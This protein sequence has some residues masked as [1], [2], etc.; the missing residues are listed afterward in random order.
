MRLRISQRR[1]D[2]LDEKSER[3][4]VV[5]LQTDQSVVWLWYSERGEGRVVAGWRGSWRLFF[6]PPSLAARQAHGR[7]AAYLAAQLKTLAEANDSSAL[8]PEYLGQSFSG[9]V[10]L[11]STA[12]PWSLLPTHGT[13]LCL[14][15]SF[16]GKALGT[17]NQM[18]K[19]L[20]SSH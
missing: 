4:I 5:G 2:W 9:E 15:L 8:P 1:I 20:F 13:S 3:L 18:N 6:G 10:D 11:I 14:S 19:A 17:S 7:S 16:S 12:S